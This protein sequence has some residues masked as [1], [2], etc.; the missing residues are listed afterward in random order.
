MTEY[1]GICDLRKQIMI[2]RIIWH[3]CLGELDAG[4]EELQICVTGMEDSF[5]HMVTCYYNEDIL[6]MDKWTAQETYAV[7]NHI[8]TMRTIIASTRR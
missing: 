4:P 7:L 3:T 1:N 2:D 5:D 6:E 8:A